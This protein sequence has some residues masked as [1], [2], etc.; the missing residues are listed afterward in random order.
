MGEACVLYACNCRISA[1]MVCLWG[2]VAVVGGDLVVGNKKPRL[3]KRGEA[4]IGFG[5]GSGGRQGFAFLNAA[6]Q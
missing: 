1:A 5:S 4:V 6:A 3:L 2:L